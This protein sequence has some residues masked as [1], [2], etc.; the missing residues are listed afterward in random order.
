MLNLIHTADIHLG[1]KL[2]YVSYPSRF[3]KERRDDSWS[4]FA[5]LLSR[6]EAD[7][8]LIAGD[9]F[10]NEYFD[11]GDLLKLKHIFTNNQNKRIIILPGNHDSYL[12]SSYNELK[13]DNVYIFKEDSLDYFQ[14]DDL[15]TRVYGIAWKNDKYDRVSIDV[16]LNP[17]FINILMLHT[18]LYSPGYMHIGLDALES[19]GFDYIALGHIHK[20]DILAPNIAYS[21]ILEGGDFQE[22]GPKGYLEVGINKMSCQIDFKNFSLRNFTEDSLELDPS[23]DQ[24]QVM[25]AINSLSTQVDLQRITLKGYLSPEVYRTFDWIKKICQGNFYYVEFLDH[26]RLEIDEGELVNNPVISTFI[27]KINESDY[28]ED[29][30]KQAIGKAIRI[31]MGD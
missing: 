15:G 3:A 22:L 23:M 11:D 30:K 9:L 8:Y 5:R 21:G 19:L 26:T 7:L 24:S 29:I 28:D 31:L 13:Q 10:E 17:K 12:A 25:E 27:K 20:A 16:D 4:S 14:F 1:R 6:K 18:D 2:E